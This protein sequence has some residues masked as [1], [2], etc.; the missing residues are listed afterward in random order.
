MFAR[1][2][3]R[4]ESP[5]H[6]LKACHSP[7][8][9]WNGFTHLPVSRILLMMDRRRC[10]IARFKILAPRLDRT[11]AHTRNGFPG[12]LEVLESYCP[13]FSRRQYTCRGTHF[14]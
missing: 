9:D 1:P 14:S 8:M 2:F 7:G 3:T 13:T 5:R 4:W 6:S 12:L 11:R 10:C